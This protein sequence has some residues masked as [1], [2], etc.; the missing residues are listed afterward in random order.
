MSIIQR[1]IAVGIAMAVLFVML[2]TVVLPFFQDTYSKAT[3]QNPAW[4]CANAGA[5][6]NCTNRIQDAYNTTPLPTDYPIVESTAGDTTWC[7]HLCLDCETAGSYR[8]TAQGLLVLGLI[9]AVIGFAVY[10]MRR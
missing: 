10:F 2:G 7:S 3:C 8:T 4:N 6:T 1:V 5:Y 9:V